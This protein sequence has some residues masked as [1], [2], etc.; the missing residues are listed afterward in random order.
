MVL[1]RRFEGLATSVIYSRGLP[2]NYDLTMPKKTKRKTSAEEQSKAEQRWAD[3]VAQFD[4]GWP[5]HSE[6]RLVS[7]QILYEM[8][9]WLK[10][11]GLNKGRRGRWDA[12]LRDRKVPLSTANDY[13]R[14]W[15]EHN[16]MPPEDCVLARKKAQQKWENNSAGSAGLTT[17]GRTLIAKIEA[18]DDEA[19]DKSG[20][21]RIGVECVFVLTMAEKILFMDA[22]KALTPLR[23]TQEMYK[24]VIA[25]APKVSGVG[26]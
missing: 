3:L 24:A 6:S 13:V 1:S 12:F 8:K 22:V 7:G 10:Q 18:A 21:R 14:L 19:A 5:I 17:S 26:A 4:R 2:F 23:A 25:A 15:Q 20:D 11:W 16:D 9:R